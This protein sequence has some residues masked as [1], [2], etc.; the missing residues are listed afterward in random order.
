MHAA[1]I[2]TGIILLCDFLVSGAITIVYM[3]TRAQV[4]DNNY[5]EL[6]M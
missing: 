6:I 3:P 5:Y 1:V 2:T 4:C